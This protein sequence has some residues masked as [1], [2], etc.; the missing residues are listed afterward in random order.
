[1]LKSNVFTEAT[2][3]E[4]A[5]F[6]FNCGY[7]ELTAT[8]PRNQE[9]GCYACF[10]RQDD[11]QVCH[12]LEEVRTLAEAIYDGSHVKHLFFPLSQEKVHPEWCLCDRC[13]SERFAFCGYED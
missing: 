4:L 11:M 9:P 5:Q 8:D 13:A 2:V 7:E 3:L 1:M 6:L 12:N 10:W